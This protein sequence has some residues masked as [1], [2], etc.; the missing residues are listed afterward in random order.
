MPP[1][2]ISLIVHP[3]HGHTYSMFTSHK[4]EKEGGREGRTADR[5]YVGERG[6][7]SNHFR[8]IGRHLTYARCLV[9]VFPRDWRGTGF[10]IGSAEGHMVQEFHHS[11]RM[12]SCILP[13]EIPWK[14]VDTV[15]LLLLP[16]V[17]ESES[18]CLCLSL[19]G[20]LD[21]ILVDVNDPKCVRKGAPQWI[22]TG[23]LT[24]G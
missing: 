22:E 23:G 11:G 13:R 3:I 21:F 7:D 9:R 1:A 10:L 18:S 6:R 16:K 15:P 20:R 14:K 12:F 24:N 19:Y 2:V 8:F 17:I 4:R 5:I